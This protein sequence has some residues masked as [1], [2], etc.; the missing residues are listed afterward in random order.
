MQRWAQGRAGSGG[1]IR[2]SKS[3]FKRRDLSI[4]FLKVTQSVKLWV[5]CFSLLNVIK[6]Q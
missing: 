1:E 6:F 3:G 5:K 4:F 2:I